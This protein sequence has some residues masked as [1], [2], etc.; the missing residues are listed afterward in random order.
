[1]SIRFRAL[2]RVQVQHAFRQA[3]SPSD[4]FSFLVP[5]ATQRNLDGLRMLARE[6][7]GQLH[8]LIELDDTGAPVAGAAAVVGQRLLFGLL[9]RH[10]G[11]AL[12]TQAPAVAAGALPLWAN[13]VD[14][15]TLAA[16]RGVALADLP[17]AAGWAD[18]AQRPAGLLQ[19]QLHADHLVTARDFALGLQARQ[20]LLRYYVVGQPFPAA[21]FDALEVVD[22]GS[23]ADGRAPITF[24][25][26]APAAFT[27][28]HLQPALL[29]ASGSARI[30]LFEAQ[31]PTARRE[32]GPTRL[33]LRVGAGGDT[34][35]AQLP[36]P[37]GE[38]PDGQFIVHLNKG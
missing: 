24:N 27:P 2:W 31:A 20:D 6:R 19:L 9:P 8:V 26:V 23:A 38:R 30:V 13:D 21:E 7:D 22:E 33:R 18:A 25:R 28:A 3:S 29:D 5:P 11:F 32:R 37:G 36:T 35:T 16:P 17:D 12:Y 14:P 15:H 34:L 1:M 10:P 4:E